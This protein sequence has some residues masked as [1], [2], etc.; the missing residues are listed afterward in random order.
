MRKEQPEYTLQKQV[1][2]Y[3][4]M[5]YPN[6]MFL[7][8]TIAAVKLT[9]PQQARNKAIQKKGFKCPDLIILKPR[10]DFLTG[11]TIHCGLFIELKVKNPFKPNGKPY[12]NPHIEAQYETLKKLSEIGYCAEF[13][14]SFEMAKNLIDTY[15][16]D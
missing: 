10:I 11:Y 14:W 12:S 4:N 1:C 16:K 8:D 9:F 5:Q 3:L 7:S 6:V 15:L 2:K 13:A